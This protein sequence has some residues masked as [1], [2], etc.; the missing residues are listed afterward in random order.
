MSP[1]DASELCESIGSVYRAFAARSHQAM[2]AALTDPSFIEDL[3]RQVASTINDQ[4]SDADIVISTHPYSTWLSGRHA[5]I[6]SL[7]YRLV[8]VHTNYSHWP[9]LRHHLVEAYVGPKL[10]FH[11]QIDARAHDIGLPPPQE[12]PPMVVLT[13]EQLEF[14][15]RRPLLLVGGADGFGPVA[16]AMRA[17]ALL[18]LPIL[19]VA[20]RNDR[21]KEELEGRYADL[22]RRGQIMVV[23]YAPELWATMSSVAAVIT[24]ASG[25]TLTDAFA[26]R[27]PV[28]CPPP[29]LAWE[30]EAMSL[31]ESSG[32]IHAIWNWEDFKPAGLHELL[33]DHERIRR[34]CAL[35]SKLINDRFAGDLID[36]VE[37][38]STRHFR[39]PKHV[40]RAIAGDLQ[41]DGTMARLRGIEAGRHIA[42]EIESYE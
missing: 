25:M 22:I 14:M 16:E 1:L 34:Q 38:Q 7:N 18:D 33:M 4:L 9:V 2:P 31:L 37:G 29:I 19:A 35:A 10:L 24:K 21:L 5:E 42:R 39:H 32:A 30:A 27:T 40:L 17:M 15:T 11:R 13:D 28:I 20:G 41:A 23:G 8:D 6:H 36:L 12:R 3:Y 26:C